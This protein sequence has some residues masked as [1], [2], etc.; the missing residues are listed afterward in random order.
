MGSKLSVEEVLANLEA[1]VAFHRRHLGGGAGRAETQG[2]R[3]SAS[4][5]KWSAVW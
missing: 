3:A 4:R 1:R 5:P 2:G